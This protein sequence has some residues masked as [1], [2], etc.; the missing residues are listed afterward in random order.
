LLLLRTNSILHGVLTRDPTAAE[1]PT[2]V[3][4]AGV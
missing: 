2:V 1:F 4:G 3:P